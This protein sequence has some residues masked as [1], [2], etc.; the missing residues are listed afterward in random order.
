[1][2]P[3][4]MDAESGAPLPLAVTGASDFRTLELIQLF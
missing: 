1:M 4:A 3:T 2:D